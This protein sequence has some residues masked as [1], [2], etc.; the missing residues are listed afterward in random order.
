MKKEEAIK[1]KSILLEKLKAVQEIIDNP[2]ITAKQRFLELLNGCE[3]KIDKEKHPNSL[4]FF[5]NGENYFEI[6]KEYFWCRYKYVWAIFESEFS[7]NYLQIQAV[8]K[9]AV[10]EHF[11]CKGSTPVILA[12]IEQN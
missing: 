11:K 6:E 7:M 3:I 2:E 5:K 10:E 4:F 1:E 8:I 9:E 12:N